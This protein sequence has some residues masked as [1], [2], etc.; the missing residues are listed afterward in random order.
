MEAYQQE[1]P[2]GLRYSAN[3]LVRRLFTPNAAPTTVTDDATGQEVFTYYRNDGAARLTALAHPAPHEW[4]ATLSINAS[5]P[6]NAQLKGYFEEEVTDDARVLPMTRVY[7]SLSGDLRVE[8]VHTGQTLFSYLAAGA[9]RPVEV[10][11]QSTAA[12]AYDWQ[13]RF[14]NAAGLLSQQ[15]VETKH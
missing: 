4:V 8:D 13:V 5:E 2:Q 10:S 3:P 14:T 15:A 6:Q 11:T 7:R 1:N 9:L 12:G